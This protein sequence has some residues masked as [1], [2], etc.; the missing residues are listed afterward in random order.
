MY[1]FER[2][3]KILNKIRSTGQITI[4]KDARLLRVSFATLHRDL[5]ELETLG[6]SRK[7]EAEPFLAKRPSLRPISTPA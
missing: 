4:K 3:D 5:A 6:S 1:P 2:K 7:S